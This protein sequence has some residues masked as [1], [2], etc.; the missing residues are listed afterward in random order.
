[1]NAEIRDPDGFEL[2]GAP[3]WNMDGEYLFDSP[4]V[5]VRNGGIYFIEIAL[6]IKGAEHAKR[7]SSAVLSAAAFLQRDGEL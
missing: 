7:V 6:P 4:R 2:D 1:M 5:V 3:H